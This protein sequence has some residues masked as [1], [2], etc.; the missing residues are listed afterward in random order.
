M[1]LFPSVKTTTR[2]K[3]VFNKTTTRG[4]NVFNKTTTR[5]K[6]VFNKTTTR[7]KN[8]FNKTTTRGKNVFNKTTTRGKNVFNKTTTRG[9]S[10]LKSFFATTTT[11]GTHSLTI[12]CAAVTSRNL[13][14]TALVF[15]FSMMLLYFLFKPFSSITMSDLFHEVM[16]Q[17]ESGKS[18]SSEKSCTSDD[19]SKPASVDNV[20]PSSFKSSDATSKKNARDKHSPKSGTLDSIDRLSDI[21]SSGFQNLQFCI[22]L[23]AL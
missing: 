1:A 13:L 16:S 12:T 4:K 20:K 11:R 18:K 8:V 15:T 2:G 7:G 5:G 17:Q 3:N 23:L 6:N 9:N 10:Y 14:V 19:L 22:H 21:P